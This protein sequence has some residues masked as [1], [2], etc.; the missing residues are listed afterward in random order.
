MGLS[1]RPA[2][3]GVRKAAYREMRETGRKRD[4]RE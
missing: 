4:I 1:R 2:L 3:V